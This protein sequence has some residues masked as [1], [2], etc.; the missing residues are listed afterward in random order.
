MYKYQQFKKIL[1]YYIVYNKQKIIFIYVINI[2][3]KT[4]I[5][6]SILFINNCYI[7]MFQIK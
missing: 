4:Y 2:I 1:F 3:I 6:C 7:I 5:E